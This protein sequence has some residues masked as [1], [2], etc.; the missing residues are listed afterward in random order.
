MSVLETDMLA[1]DG[2]NAQPDRLATHAVSRAATIA[3][4]RVG[5]NVGARR[6]RP[7]PRRVR[8]CALAGPSARGALRQAVPARTVS[9]LAFEGRAPPSVTMRANS[10]LRL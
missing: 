4:I 7:M 2:R 8:T 9:S 3:Q 6:G 10:A 5:Q 1:S